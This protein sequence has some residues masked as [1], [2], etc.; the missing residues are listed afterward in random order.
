MKKKP[1]SIST[2]VRNPARLRNFLL[3]LADWEDK[4]FDEKTQREFQVRLICRRLYLPTKIP[5]EYRENF[6]NPEQAIC[7]SF[8]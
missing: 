5:D 8:E 1:W 7:E 3:V 4:P 2:T 6:E